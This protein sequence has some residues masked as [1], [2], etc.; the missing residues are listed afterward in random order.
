M[1]IDFNIEGLDRINQKLAKYPERLAKETLSQLK[2]EARSLSKD[3]A[4]ETSPRG[5]GERARRQIAKSIDRD[6]RRLFPENELTTGNA[7]QVYDILESHFDK[8]VADAFWL[9]FK[10]GNHEKASKFLRRRGLPRGVRAEEYETRRKQKGGV[11]R[12]PIALAARS[13][14]ESMI[15]KKQKRIGMAKAGWYQAARGVG[16]RL[17]TTSSASGKAVAAF[18][19]WVIAAGRGLNLGGARVVAGANPSVTI[20]SDV[21][22]GRKALKQGVMT[23]ALARTELRMKKVLAKKIEAENRKNF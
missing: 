6:V 20:F 1:N 11:G 8:G 19:K 17:R 14:I 22:H 2:M 23:R 7:S 16:G 9:Q 3:L 10:S 21:R 5:F 12:K 13:R 18:P 4:Y 15:R